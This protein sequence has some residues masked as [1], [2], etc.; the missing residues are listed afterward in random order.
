MHCGLVAQNR[1]ALAIIESYR[2]EVGVDARCLFVALAE[3]V[4]RRAD[5]RLRDVFLICKPSG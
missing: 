1:Q 4:N 3:T 5:S 2:D